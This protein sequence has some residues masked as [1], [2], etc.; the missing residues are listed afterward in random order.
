MNQPAD[1]TSLPESPVEERRR[2]MVRYSVTMLIRLL[3]IA[4]CFF[5]EGWWLLVPAFGAVVLPYVAVVLANASDGS[6]PRRVTR[7]GSIV[8]SRPEDRP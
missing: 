8:R 1:I 5:V 4:A 7:P 6:A 2:R 3:C